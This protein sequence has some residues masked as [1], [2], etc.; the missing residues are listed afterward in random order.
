VKISALSL[1]LGLVMAGVAIAGEDI[2]IQA[3]KFPAAYSLT[4]AHAAP[5]QYS[6]AWQ[7][8]LIA[9]QIEFAET[10]VPKIDNIET[11]SITSSAQ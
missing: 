4:S 7:R 11:G 1:F 2:R 9:I 8:R 3:D 6:K 10:L 5:K